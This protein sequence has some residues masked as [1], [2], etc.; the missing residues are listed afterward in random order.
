MAAQ[1]GASS[2]SPTSQSAGTYDV[3]LSFRGS[4]TRNN[5]V[6]HLYNNLVQKGIKTF[7]D[8]DE[9]EGGQEIASTLLKAIQ[10]S[11][12]LVVVFSKTYA[13][14]KWCLDELVKIID[15]K[16]LNHQI[17]CYP[18][19]YK[20]GPSEVR[21]QKGSFAEAFAKHELR[22]NSETVGRW[23]IALTQAAEVSGQ[24]FS[25]GG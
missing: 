6:G 18:V 16:K 5:F 23:K 3:F 17:V 22:Y 7:R 25:D 14:S 15:C 1:F 19:F 20:V 24:Q 13:T 12:I 2:S 9:L 10:E 4:D 8:D 11:K 21:Y